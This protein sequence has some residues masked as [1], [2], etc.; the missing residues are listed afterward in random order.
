MSR[1]GV[2]R[3]SR[4]AWPADNKV[5]RDWERGKYKKPT[6]V[7]AKI[8]IDRIRCGVDCWLRKEQTGH[9]GRVGKQPNRSSYYRVSLNRLTNDK[10]HCIWTFSDLKRASDS[11]HWEGLWRYGIPEKIV[12]MMKRIYE[13][14]LCVVEDQRGR[15]DWLDVNSGVKQGCKYLDFCF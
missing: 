2:G 9:I 3:D 15:C 8:L 11:I 12:R 6:K 4:V 10:R 13:Y 7:L 5:W 1:A 14:F